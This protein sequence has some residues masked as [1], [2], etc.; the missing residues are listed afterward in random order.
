MRGIR[1]I[2][3]VETAMKA[4]LCKGAIK[5]GTSCDYLEA[6]GR[7]MFTFSGISYLRSG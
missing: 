4:V 6:G 7:A 2:K 1:A 5:T 3:I